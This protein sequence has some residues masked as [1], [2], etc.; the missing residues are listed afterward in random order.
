MEVMNKFITIKRHIEGAPQES[1]FELKTESI[2]LSVQAGSNDVIVKTFYLSID[3]YQLNRMKSYSS[4]QKAHSFAVGIIPGEA[5]DAFGLGRVVASGH[6]GFEKDDLVAGVITWGEYSLIKGAVMLNKLDTMG[7]PLSYHVGILGF[8]GLTA[9]GGFFQVCRPKK[10]EKVFVSAASGS[11]GNLVGQYAKLFGCYVVGCAGTKQKVELLKEKLG[12]DDAF[13]YKEE[14]DLKSTLK[15]YFPDGIDI[16]F[17]NVG[18]DMLEAAVFNMN[19]F[20]RVAVCGVISEYT[21][22]A[23]R[24]APDMLD[25]IYKRIAIQGFLA[26]DQM[27]VYADFLSTTAD[28]LRNGKMKVLE[29]ISHGVESIPTTFMALFSGDNIGKT[30]VQIIADV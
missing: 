24:A 27:N 25:V 16:Y 18:G 20:G 17:D 11:V 30:I 2:S 23:K 19:T 9:Y 14:T 15:R 10:G 7:L 1:D 13:N 29:D 4:S 6:P 8:S 26:A 28:H 22:V 5:I 3:P 12:F 21:D